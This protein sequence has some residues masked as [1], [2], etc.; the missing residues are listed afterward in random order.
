METVR[1]GTLTDLMPR[2]TRQ[3]TVRVSEELY[4]LIVDDSTL[5]GR[6]DGQTI[7]FRLELAYGLRTPE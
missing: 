3:I 5:H 7:R 6:T 2:L 4:K 1:S